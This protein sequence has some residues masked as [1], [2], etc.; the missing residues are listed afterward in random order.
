L[1]SNIR[2][3]VAGILIAWQPDCGVDLTGRQEA[4][5]DLQHDGEQ[6]ALGEIKSSY[7]QFLFSHG[8]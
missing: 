5:G 1:I 6:S 7:G 8:I 4:Y 3:S 2:N